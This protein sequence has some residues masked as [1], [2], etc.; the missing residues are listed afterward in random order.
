MVAAACADTKGE[1]H[2]T[3][4]RAT[5]PS[6][7]WLCAPLREPSMMHRQKGT[8]TAPHG[9]CSFPKEVEGMKLGFGEVASVEGF[10]R[11]TE[12]V[13][14]PIGSCNQDWLMRLVGLKVEGAQGLIKQGKCPFEPFNQANKL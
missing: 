10:Y 13:S 4:P 6:L 11:E 2:D 12:N 7:H 8:A 9:P 3:V 1:A 14:R 5:A